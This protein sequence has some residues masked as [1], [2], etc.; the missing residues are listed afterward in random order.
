MS[1]DPMYNYKLGQ[2]VSLTEAADIALAKAKNLW[3]YEKDVEARMFRDLSKEIRLLA[4][5]RH[6]R[7]DKEA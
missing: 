6:P 4:S 2:S 3:Q 7:K 1:N 5:E